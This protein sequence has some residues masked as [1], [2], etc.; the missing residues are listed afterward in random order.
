M[1]LEKKR[2]NRIQELINEIKPK[3]GKRIKDQVESGRFPYTYAYDF[4]RLGDGSRSGTGTYL[5]KEFENNVEGYA[6]QIISRAFSYLLREYAD[7]FL[8]DI[9]EEKDDTIIKETYIFIRDNY[10][11]NMNA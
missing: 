10:Y 9:L 1:E 5:R 6:K 7:D 8:W 11:I 3:L 2:S 4:E